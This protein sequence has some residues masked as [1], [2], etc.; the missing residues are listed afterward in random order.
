MVRPNCS[1]TLA[2]STA[3]SRHHL[4][5]PDASA[6]ASVAAT[7]RTCALDSGSTASSLTGTSS[8]VTVPTRE[9][10]SSGA[11]TAVEM[12]GESSGTTSQPA[13]SS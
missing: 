2:Y 3:V 5:V 1:R 7:E 13:S 11:A 9:E 6:A 10:K 8:R 12:P 4:A